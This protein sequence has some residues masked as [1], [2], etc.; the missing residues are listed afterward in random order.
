MAVTAGPKI[1]KDNLV[2][3]MDKNNTV[4]SWKG[5]P[6]VNYWYENGGG[7]ATII[8]VDDL[9]EVEELAK[10]LGGKKNIR[11]P[12]RQSTQTNWL[13][14]YNSSTGITVQPGE[15]LRISCYVY[16]EKS[17]NRFNANANWGATLGTNAGMY[18]S[19]DSHNIEPYKWHRITWLKQNTTES[20]INV[21]NSRIETYSTGEWSPDEIDAY[22]TNPQWEIGDFTTPFVAGTRSDTEAFIDPLNGIIFNSGNLDNYNGDGS[23]DFDGDS[24]YLYVN[25]ASEVPVLYHKDFTLE[26]WIKRD[27]TGRHDEILG[28]YQYGWFSFRISNGNQVVLSLTDYI[29]GAYQY[30]GITGTTTINANEWYH[31]AI[32]WVYGSESRVYV[33]GS[34]DKTDSESYGAGY[35]GS[36]RG[37]RYIG[38]TTTGAPNAG[39]ERY[40]KGEIGMVKVYEDKALTATEV[41]TNFEA[42]RD[43]YGV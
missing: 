23:F 13:D 12:R 18:A 28:D 20:A 1:I 17:T 16:T 11:N 38:R 27:E 33:N 19:P 22:C 3:Y 34:L 14:L 35:T 30:P 40:F 37:P 43:R 42:S 10:L 39:N 21:S 2:M 9:P 5:K 26:A 36:G 6:T 7:G 24:D 41:L 8:S 4:R 31:V 15:K 32:T 29:E 25:T